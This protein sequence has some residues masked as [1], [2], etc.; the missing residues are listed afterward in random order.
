MIHNILHTARRI[1]APFALFAL[2]IAHPSAHA[3]LSF[4]FNCAPDIDPR[5]LVG[6]EAA[7]ARWSSLFKDPINVS[8]DVGFEALAPGVLGSTGSSS[9]SLSYSAFKYFLS[10][11][12]SSVN[13]QIAYASLSSGL[14]FDLLLN[15]TSNSPYGSASATP[16]LDNDGNANNSTIRMNLANARALGIYQAN[17]GMIDASIRFSSLFNFDFDPTDGVASDAIDFVGVA[18]HELGHALGFTSGLLYV[19][20]MGI[21]PVAD[22]SLRYV[23]PLDLYRYS[24]DS[25]AQ[26]A[27]DWTTDARTKYFSIDGGST[28][29]ALFSTGMYGDGR[30]PSHWKDGYDFGIM[31]PTT[32][33]GELDVIRSLDVLALDVIGYDIATPEPSTYGMVAVAMLGLAVHFRRRRRRQPHQ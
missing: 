27:T 11:D 30:Q 10:A 31:D 14:S 24:V 1:A 18:T 3:Q 22:D 9:L 6:F 17:G 12:R 26:K 7:A 4:T 5:A 28:P 25:Y 16:Y 15:R 8:I 32:A 33:Y 19:D 13:D 2:A 21:A 23:S 20:A 29:L